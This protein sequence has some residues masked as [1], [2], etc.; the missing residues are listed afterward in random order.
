MEFKKS[1]LGSPQH[2]ARLSHHPHDMGMIRKFTSSVGQLLPVY[3]DILYPGDKVKYST[4]MFSR[5]DTLKTPAMIQLTQHVDW[6]FVP[7]NQIYQ[8]YGNWVYG[9]TDNITD[10][11]ADGGNP[12]SPLPNLSLFEYYNLFSYHIGQSGKTYADTNSDRDMFDIPKVY[13]AARLYELLGYSNKAMTAFDTAAKDKKVNPFLLC[14][15]QKIFYDHYRLTDRT[16][17][18]QSS[19]NLDSLYATATI[20]ALRSANLLQM[21]YRPWKKDFFTANMPKPL[22]GRGSS[23][24]DYNM[25]K[26]QALTNVNDWLGLS[27]NQ[28]ASNN[29]TIELV[30]PAIS[31]G[32][33]LNFTTADLRHMFA[34]EKLMEITRHAAKH[35]DAQTLAHFGQKVPEGIAGEVYEL[36][37]DISSIRINDIT[38]N[39]TVSGGSTLG[40]LGGNGVSYGQNK[41]KKFTAPCHGILMAI[42]SCVPEAD[43]ASSGLHRF[44]SYSRR[45][46]Y[47]QPELERLGEQ[48]LFR[49][50]FDSTPDSGFGDAVGWQW[51]YMESKVKYN[52]TNGGFNYTARAW[53][54]HRN[55]PDYPLQFFPMSD[56]YIDPQYLDDVLQA[57]FHPANTDPLTMD[58]CFGRDPLKHMFQFHVIKSSTLSP[59]SLPQL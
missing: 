57:S 56:Y 42:Y 50:Q 15:Y 16:P 26:N 22:A 33:N 41:K 23:L 52:E 8:F 55:D 51:R 11:I 25:N 17:N 30:S 7:M 20:P 4:E 38:A 44:N 47:V 9:I 21:H 36:G 54:T 27:S 32:D 34:V 46:D 14:A 18:S 24:S 1:S 3:F 28:V 19:Y 49:Y 31:E 6:F 13:N 2:I 59:F 58:A 53:S 48:P 12:A 37:S 39:A 5:L 10:F 40:Q 43:Y 35:Y 29:Q 45:E